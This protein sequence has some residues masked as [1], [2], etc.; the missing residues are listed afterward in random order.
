LTRDRFVNVNGCV[1]DV[2]KLSNEIGKL[3]L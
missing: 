2:V 1:L 3:L